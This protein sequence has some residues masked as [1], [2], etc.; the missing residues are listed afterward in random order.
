VF[1]GSSKLGD[2]E[3]LKFLRSY[4][5]IFIEH[6]EKETQSK[7][8]PRLTEDWFSR[9][10]ELDIL[11]KDGKLPPQASAGDH[12][13]PDDADAMNARY[14]LTNEERELYGEAIKTRKHV[15]IL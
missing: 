10:P 15:S 12:N 13:A 14:K 6:T 9:W 4:V 5:P 7:F 3:Q 8:W 2:H 11:I 1:H